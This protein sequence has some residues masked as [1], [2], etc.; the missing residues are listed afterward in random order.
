[1]KVEAGEIRDALR[2]LHPPIEG[3]QADLR[4]WMAAMDA[5]WGILYD[6]ELR[7]DTKDYWEARYSRG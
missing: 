3:N 2:E 5:V 6:I 7:Q 1:M 4:G